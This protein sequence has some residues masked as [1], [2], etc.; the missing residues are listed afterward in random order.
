[1]DAHNA[2][3]VR[4]FAQWA[5][6]KRA[7]DLLQT[8]EY[9]SAALKEPKETTMGIPAAPARSV[10]IVGLGA[11]GSAMAVRLKA[12]GYTVTGTDVRPASIAELVS[13]GGHGAPSA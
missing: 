12:A 7:A 8:Q 9:S 4:A 11:M 10:G 2:L 1:M 13:N 3:V 6:H 5:M